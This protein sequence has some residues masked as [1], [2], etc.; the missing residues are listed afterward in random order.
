MVIYIKVVHLYNC[1]RY[2]R[3]PCGLIP[4]S[5]LNH[6]APIGVERIY[7][8]PY[9]RNVRAVLRHTALQL[10]VSSSGLTRP[11]MG[12][13]HGQKPLLSKKG[14]GPA[15]MISQVFSRS[16]APFLVPGHFPPLTPFSRAVNIRSVQMDASTQDQR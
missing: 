14:I 8:L 6:P 7:I 16:L 2:G 12:L 4:A 9:L 11:S 1:I 5:L 13:L 3:A 15:F 10:V